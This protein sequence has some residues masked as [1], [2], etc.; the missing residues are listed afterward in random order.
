VAFKINY[1]FLDRLIHRIAFSNIS[2]QLFSSD[3]EN[4]I[5]SGI[6]SDVIV[7]KPIF[8][9]SLPR[10][11]TTLLLEAFNVLPTMAT[12]TYRDMP[13]VMAPVLWNKFNRAF[14]KKGESTERAHNDGMTISYDSP[15]AFEEI[16]W[17]AFWPEKYKDSATLLFDSSDQNDAATRFITNN[18]RKIISLRCPDNKGEGRYISK[19]N[20][21]VARLHLIKKMFP[22]AKIL[23]PVRDPFEHAMSLLRQHKNFTEMHRTNSF[24]RQYMQD[25]GHFEFGA[26]HKPIMFPEFEDWTSY[27]RDHFD[28][29]YWVAYWIA[30]YKYILDNKY[31]VTCVPYESTCLNPSGILPGIIEE[32]EIFPDDHLQQIYELFH[33]P[34]DKRADIRAINP[35]LS[36][37]AMEIHSALLN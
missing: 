11:G 30:A 33:K 3:I 4:G 35:S 18:M 14:Q 22:D 8:I 29:N 19:N 21:N 6:Y 28:I 5:Y 17:H 26:L 1:S 2:L 23:I 16:L 12:H 7:K 9:T 37:A 13:F 27:C 24:I 36:K 15:E 34:P 10:A 20:G 32:L 31:L 25:I